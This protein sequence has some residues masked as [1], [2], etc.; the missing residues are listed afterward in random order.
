MTVTVSDKFQVVIPKEIREAVALTKGTQVAVL[1]KG[2]I[3]YI[4]PVKPISKLRGL[5]K[6]SLSPSGLRDKKDRNL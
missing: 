2:G 4:V 6:P 5:A 3:V 1:A